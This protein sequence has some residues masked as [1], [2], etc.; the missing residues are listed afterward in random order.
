M[1]KLIH[2]GGISMSRITL[3]GLVLS[4]IVAAPT[5]AW[6]GA[7][8]NGVLSIEV[9]IER[10]ES[11]DLVVVEGEIIDFRSGMGSLM[12]AT[13]EDDTGRVAIAV[14]QYIRRDIEG[15]PGESPLHKRIRVAGKWDNKYMDKETWGI[16]AQKVELI[17]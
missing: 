9:V 12:I 17:D 3:L 15:T 10:A 8:S 13:L 11:G 1:R 2:L 7:T 14:P 16:R 4:A 6:K 5:L